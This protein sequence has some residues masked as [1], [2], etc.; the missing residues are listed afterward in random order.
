MVKILLKT[1]INVHPSMGEVVYIDKTKDSSGRYVN[2]PIFTFTF[3]G[4]LLS[5]IQGETYNTNTNELEY[6]SY[7]PA[8]GKMYTV[9]NNTEMRISEQVAADKCTNGKNYKYRYRL[10]QNDPQT[11]LPMCDN[12]FSRGKIE[13]ETTLSTQLQLKKGIKNMHSPFYFNYDNNPSSDGH[14][15]GC[16]YIEIGLERRMVLSYDSSTGIVTINS[17]FTTKPTIN[18]PY[19]LYCNYI[20]TGY[21]DF[22]AREYPTTNI[23]A[24]PISNGIKCSA[25]YQQINNIGLKSYKFNIYRQNSDS[26]KLT[27]SL[28]NA[29]NSYDGK[30]DLMHIPIETGIT[31][32]LS[33]LILS[34]T[35]VTNDESKI[36]TSMIERY[37]AITGIV[38]LKYSLPVMPLPASRYEIYLKK[39]TLIETMDR[40][41]SYDLTNT[42]PVNALDNHF[43]IEC[44]LTTQEDCYAVQS[45]YKYYE[46][47][48]IETGNI[49]GIAINEIENESI[50]RTP[51]AHISWRVS[52]YS[53]NYMIFRKDCVTGEIVYI[54][55]TS[56]VHYTDYT[57]ANNHT[58][59]Y[60]IV[61]CQ[62]E[63]Q[64]KMYESSKVVTDFDGWYI[65]SIDYIDF[66]LNRRQYNIGDTWHFISTINSGSITNNI[67]STLHVGTSAYTKTSR[68]NSRYTSGSFT[69]DLLTISCPAGGLKDDIERV[70]KW[71]KFITDNKT[72]LLK[73]EKGDVW[74]VNIVNSPSRTYE[75]TANPI[76]TNVTYE[77][78]EVGDI[79]KI[80][81]L[82]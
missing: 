12:Y 33:G 51:Y 37:D 27:G 77:W 39:E 76:F 58:Y 31:E 43:R 54:G 47:T 13:G 17:P 6:W 9:H 52:A 38:T 56:L 42:F 3:Q 18:T 67:N 24:E 75:E 23:T 5:W 74:V 69:A 68:D 20:E 50:V 59:V 55:Q 63:E 66:E 34:V 30:I 32:N 11:G 64:K 45:I 81:I 10:F 46:S 19:E 28:P 73:S 7:C 26:E 60:Q 71:I 61:V 79:N 82:S 72:F 14:L 62:D 44:E 49:L 22:K 48:E 78:A 41:Y 15:I 29:Y 53:D 65:M 70:N 21:Y 40:D 80:V 2:A 35:C 57:I 25:T 36:V 8:D 4:D 1:P 16:T